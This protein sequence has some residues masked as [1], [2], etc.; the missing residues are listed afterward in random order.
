MFVGDLSSCSLPAP[1]SSSGSS[2]PGSLDSAVRFHFCSFGRQVAH[3]RSTITLQISGDKLHFF[4]KS[5]QMNTCRDEGRKLPGMSTYENYP[6]GRVPCYV[7]SRRR[8]FT[9]R[10]SSTTAKAG[11][12]LF[13][14]ISRRTQ[15][16]SSPALV[17]STTKLP[18]KENLR[19]I[20]TYKKT[21]GGWVSVT[22]QIAACGPTSGRANTLLSS[23]TCPA[24]CWSNMRPPRGER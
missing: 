16:S 15:A 14:Y 7:A 12:A 1:P 4:R 2:R 23:R 24:L 3:G 17:L 20:N 21:P 9:A 5:R 19:R 8:R 22:L 10:P 18:A 13:H 6:G 11:S